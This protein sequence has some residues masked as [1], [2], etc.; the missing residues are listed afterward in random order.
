MKKTSTLIIL[1]LLIAFPLSGQSYNKL[2]NPS[3]RFVS[4][5]GFVNITGVEGAFGLKDSTA[6]NSKYYF[7][8]T[9][10]FG[11]QSDRNF[12]AGIG[13][14]LYFCENKLFVPFYLENKYSFYLKGF[15]P[16]F[17]A[18][19]GLLQ[20]LDNFFNESKIFI[21]PG[22]GI[23]RYVSPKIEGSLSVGYMLQARTT[24]NRISFLNFRLSII[25]RDN[26]YR[27]FKKPESEFKRNY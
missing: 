24:L 2:S 18:D 5:P 12:F 19:G 20:S 26:P 21:N 16:F 27:M 9:D 25:Y 7:S 17:Y 15:T 8:L 23:S 4:S 14:G 1:I 6:T 13:V 10:V 11:Y 3:Y 22:I